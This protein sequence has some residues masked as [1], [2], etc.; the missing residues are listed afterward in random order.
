MHSLI[1]GLFQRSKTETMVV[2]RQRIKLNHP[3]LI[4]DNNILQEIEHHKHLGIIFSSD[5]TG[6]NHIIKITTKG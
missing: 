3:D 4:M 5:L 1:S 2:S 6:H